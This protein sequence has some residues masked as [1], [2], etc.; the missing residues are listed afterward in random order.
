MTGVEPARASRT[1][2]AA[3]QACNLPLQA[4]VWL[5]ALGQV[6]DLSG[7]YYLRLVGFRE[8]R[9]RREVCPNAFMEV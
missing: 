2:P 1:G 3:S 4:S 5:Q 9:G 7:I 6:D 8:Q